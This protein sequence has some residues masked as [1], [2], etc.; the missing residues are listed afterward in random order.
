MAFSH[1]ADGAH[2]LL[3]VLGSRHV[4]SGL[5]VLGIRRSILS[6]VLMWLS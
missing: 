1:V 5:R 4:K 6:R 2:V 3:V